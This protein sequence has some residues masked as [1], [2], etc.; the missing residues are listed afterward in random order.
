MGSGSGMDGSG[1]VV[2]PPRSVP[3]VGRGGLIWAKV[4]SDVPAS[5]IPTIPKD[6]IAASRIANAFMQPTRL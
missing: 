6:S 4:T 5:I 1:M 2:L 3:L